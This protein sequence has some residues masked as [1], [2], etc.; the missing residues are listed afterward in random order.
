MAV[1]ADGQ[2]ALTEWNVVSRHGDPGNERTLLACRPHTGRQHQIRVH[3]EAIGHP[4]VGDKLYGHDEACFQRSADGELSALDLERL[5]L[6]RQ[7]LHNHRLEFIS[8]AS[9]ERV[10]VVSPLASDLVQYLAER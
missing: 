8:P 6:P 7:A 3:L 2:P 10:R 4:I 9:G 5:E 1:L